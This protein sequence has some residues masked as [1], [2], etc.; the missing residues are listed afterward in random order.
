LL[1]ALIHCGPIGSSERAVSGSEAA[2]AKANAAP[3]PSMILETVL[4][5]FIFV[6][7]V[8]LVLLFVSE[9]TRVLA[10]VQP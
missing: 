9:Q 3:M 6:S 5:V 4:L 7:F 2:I 1:L 8:S 10:F